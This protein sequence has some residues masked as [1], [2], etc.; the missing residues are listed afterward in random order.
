MFTLATNEAD[1]VDV[2]QFEVFQEQQQD[3]GDGLHNDLLVAIDVDPELHA[4]QH[5]G[6]AAEGQS[7]RPYPV[8]M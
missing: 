2:V 3:G 4:L 5:R 8:V 1:L 7:P 6:P